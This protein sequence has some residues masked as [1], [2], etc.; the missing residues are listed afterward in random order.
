MNELKF[1]TKKKKKT[2]GESSFFLCFRFKFR[3][4]K[5]ERENDSVCVCGVCYVDECIIMHAY[6]SK[7]IVFF[8]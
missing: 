1:P 2:S 3:I 8:F 7:N 4:S 5:Y 6:I